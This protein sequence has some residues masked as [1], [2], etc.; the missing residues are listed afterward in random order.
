MSGS[1]DSGNIQ[2]YLCLN[3][4]RVFAVCST[5]GVAR[6][7]AF[8]FKDQC[9]QV[10]AVGSPR[11]HLLFCRFLSRRHSHCSNSLSLT[12]LMGSAPSVARSIEVCADLRVRLVQTEFKLKA[13]TDSYRA[14]S[15]LHTGTRLRLQQEMQALVDIKSGY[16]IQIR[17]LEQT[18]GSQLESMITITPVEATSA[19]GWLPNW[20]AQ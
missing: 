12:Y 6:P 11:L 3:P 17:S 7:G 15:I 18:T 14:T 8:I 10:C 20:I 2:P 5:R 9:W 13:L 16:E 19:D 1:G 4:S